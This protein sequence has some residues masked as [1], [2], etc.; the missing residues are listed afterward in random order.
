MSCLNKKIFII[1]GAKSGKPNRKNIEAD[2]APM[3]KQ[4]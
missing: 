2:A 1:F 3:Q 4:I